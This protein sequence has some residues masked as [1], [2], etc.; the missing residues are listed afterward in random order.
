MLLRR[1]GYTTHQKIPGDVK[2]R[3]LSPQ[4]GY[5]RKDFDQGRQLPWNAPVLEMV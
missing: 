4:D 2:D 1:L 5:Q 3:K